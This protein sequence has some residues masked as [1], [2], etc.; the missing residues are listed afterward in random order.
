MI[1]IYGA[2]QYGSNLFKAINEHVN[3]DFFIDEYSGKTQLFSRPVYRLKDAPSAKI[4]NSVATYEND[5]YSTISAY[6]AKFKFVPFLDT[7][8]EYPAIISYFMRENYL[9][10]REDSPLLPEKCD[11]INLFKD[12]VSL[13]FI[14]KWINFRKSLNPS[15]H[16]PAPTNS[17]AEQYFPKD[18]KFKFTTFIDCGGFTGDTISACASQARPEIIAAFEPDPDNMTKLQ[19]VA[20]GI[21]GPKILIYP[22]GVYSETTILRFQCTGSSSQIHEDGNITVPATS[23]DETVYTARPDYIKM[24]VEGVEREAILGAKSII[25][26]LTPHLAVCIYHKPEDLWELPTLINEI[27]PHYDFYIRCHNHLCLETVLYCVR[28]NHD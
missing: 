25:R 23:L 13:D 12:P 15:L 19:N 11:F 10:L 14:D 16:Y 3:I 6:G 22:C 9:W 27:N 24:D 5:V 18:I 7:L 8:R 20:K 17:L 4:Y 1:G 21:I 2:G 26:D 28:K